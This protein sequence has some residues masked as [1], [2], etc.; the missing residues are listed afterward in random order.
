MRLP[1]HTAP[2]ACAVG[3]CVGGSLGAHTVTFASTS[4]STSL[5]T[6]GVPPCLPSNTGVSAN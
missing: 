2:T 4:L 1:R 3:P 6:H 5:R